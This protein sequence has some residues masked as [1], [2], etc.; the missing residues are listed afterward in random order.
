MSGI[1]IALHAYCQVK[2]HNNNTFKI[3]Y[4][5]YIVTS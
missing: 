5:E 1:F 2:L 3:I 4:S